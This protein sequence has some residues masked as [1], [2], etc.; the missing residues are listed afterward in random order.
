LAK[1]V[2]EYYSE[3]PWNGTIRVVQRQRQLWMGGTDPLVPIGNH[4]F[5]IG[6]EATSPGVAEFSEL[7]GEKPN[8]L[9][10]DGVQFRR[11]EEVTS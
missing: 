9:W 2:G 4:L 1:Y 3:N 5:R 10:I 6:T 11:I 8:L 7:I